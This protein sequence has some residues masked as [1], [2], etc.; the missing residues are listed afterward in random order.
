M[1]LYHELKRRNVFRVAIAYLALAWLLTEVSG[2]LFPAFGIPD[3]GV[4]FVVIVF[5]LGFVPAVIISWVYELT[6][7]GIKR[8][9]DVVRDSSIT[10]LTAK[11][12]DLFT[13]GLIVVA[14]A[15]L[16]ADRFWLGPRHPEQIAAPAAIVTDNGQT[17]KPE[18]TEPQYPPNSIAVLPFVNMSDD[19]GNEYF[20][21]G[22]SEELLNLLSK[23]PELRVTSRSSAF[24]FKGKDFD[25]PTIAA[26]LD[27]AHILEGSV[28]K[29]GN[30]VRITAQL[31][32][33]RSDTH[34][35]SETYDRELENIFAIQDEISAAI[36]GALKERLE[37]EVEAAPRVIAAA[38]TEAYEAYLRGRYLVIQR[39]RATIEGAV[40][41]FEKAIALDPDYALAYAELS[42][43]IA[44]LPL[45]V[46]LTATEAI[47]PAALYARAALYAERAM[48]LDPN[49]AEAHA[50]AGM[51]LWWGQ[52]AYEEVLT[53]FERAIQINPNYSIVYNWMSILFG[54][55]GRYKER[56]ALE[57]TAL[58]LD[59][60]SKVV[61]SNYA[62]SLSRRNRLDEADRE[63]AKLASIDP[64]WYAEA[65]GE[66]TALGGK[67]A[68]VAL[69]SL[70]ALL[71][72]PES[73]YRT[74]LRQEFAII[75]LEPEALSLLKTTDSLVLSNS[76]VLNLLG[77]HGDAVKTAEARD[78]TRP[79]S[80]RDLGLALTAAGDYARARPFLEEMWQRNTRRVTQTGWF[81]PDHAAALIAIRRNVGEEAGVGELLAAMRDNVRRYREAGISST[82]WDLNVDYEEGLVTYLSGEHEKGLALIATA[83]E[84]GY[85]IFPKVAYLQTL[86]DDP[87]F[88]P[89]L[90]SQEARQLRERNRF[91][92]IV[93]TDNP[94]EAVWQPA[95]GTCERFAAEQKN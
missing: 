77:R 10:H 44:L 82:Y 30:Q 49:L 63:L 40:R 35:W 83:V 34:L 80:R 21:D 36:V 2:T 76:W 68:N 9:K 52:S 27:V 47:A 90:A 42:L 54:Q 50:A 84:D 72:D 73:H 37:L 41:E 59:P 4:R 55:L 29:A 58:R 11:R 91:L 6:P 5:A 87:G 74:D 39:T 92:T 66:L 93:C 57:E 85:F 71:I 19:A 75:G 67:W 79:A 70:N 81:Q 62:F 12:L 65:R 13:I 86:Y 56:F 14:L 28:R 25:I 94:Y 69:G 22:I 8:E 88:A 15:F 18:P 33:T 17:S 31:I 20:A 46:D 95:E 16:L 61:I 51:L 89:I 26:Q 43:A 1:S 23:I 3:W 7:E 38:S 32:E 48:A 60:L 53:A 24:S 64:V 78:P 45:Y